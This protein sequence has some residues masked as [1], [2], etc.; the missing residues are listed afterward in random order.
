[1]SYTARKLIHDLMDKENGEDV[2][3]LFDEDLYL[4]TG[5]S[6]QPDPY[7]NLVL[8]T[9]KILARGW[10][11]HEIEA[12]LR[13]QHGFEHQWASSLPTGRRERLAQ[14]ELDHRGGPYWAG[15]EPLG[16]VH[17]NPE[18]LSMIEEV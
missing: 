12:H 3:I 5:V 16:H 6:S 18:N 17:P 14:H 9:S 2:V 10:H 11:D 4:V 15:L 1:M 13:D 8:T 7:G